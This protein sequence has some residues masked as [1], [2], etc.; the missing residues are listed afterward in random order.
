MPYYGV[1]GGGGNGTSDH[2]LLSGRSDASQHP[3]SA[4]A[5][6]PIQVIG[7]NAG[8]VQE[9]LEWLADQGGRKEISPVA[10]I[11]IGIYKAAAFRA[12][13]QIEPADHDNPAH[14]SRL[15]GI[16]L[17]SATAGTATRVCVSGPVRFIGWNWQPGA[18]V[19]VGRNGE[20]AQ[21]PPETGFVQHI[22]FALGR[23]SLLVQIERAIRR[24]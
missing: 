24:G 11:A 4:V 16:T 12:D 8:T 23:D 5:V 2:R 7:P 19:F 17:A 6:S 18:P 15:A 20:L 9:T 14:L 10:A 13:G 21:T 3:A 22:G 1:I